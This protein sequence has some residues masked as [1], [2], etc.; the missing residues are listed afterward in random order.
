MLG[1]LI[2][3]PPLAALRHLQSGLN[4][5]LWHPDTNVQN[6]WRISTELYTGQSLCRPASGLPIMSVFQIAVTNRIL[7]H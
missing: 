5:E 2:P 3:F 7:P 6:A 4:K 1:E